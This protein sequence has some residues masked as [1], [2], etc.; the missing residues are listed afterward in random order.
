MLTFGDFKYEFDFALARRGESF[1]DPWNSATVID[2][3]IVDDWSPDM[4]FQVR[5]KSDALPCSQAV[6]LLPRYT[7]LVAQEVE[8]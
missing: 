4:P 7:V 1:G 6:M 3:V 2:Y 5:L 8:L